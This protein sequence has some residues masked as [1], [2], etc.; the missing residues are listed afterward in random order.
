MEVMIFYK[1][2]MGCDL[3]MLKLAIDAETALLDAKGCGDFSAE[4]YKNISQKI[5]GMTECYKWRLTQIPPR[6]A[7][8]FWIP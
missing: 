2:W 8:I 7:I 1:W 6:N 5:A 3:D 4:Y